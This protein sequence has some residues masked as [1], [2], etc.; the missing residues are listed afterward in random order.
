MT[1]NLAGDMIIRMFL[2]ILIMEN[3]TF[4]THIKIILKIFELDSLYVTTGQHYR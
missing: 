3:T 1:F 4:L 2:R